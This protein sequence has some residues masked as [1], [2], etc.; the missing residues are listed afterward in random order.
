[1]ILYLAQFQNEHY[2]YGPIPATSHFASDS[3]D[4]STNSSTSGP[5][6]VCDCKVLC[7][8]HELLFS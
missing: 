6:I 3:D 5:S 7:F 1:M 2:P 4:Y 8:R